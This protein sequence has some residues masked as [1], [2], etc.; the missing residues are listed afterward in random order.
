MPSP[1]PPHAIA[2]TVIGRLIHERPDR[3]S[4]EPGGSMLHHST[5]SPTP[6]LR[7]TMSPTRMPGGAAFLDDGPGPRHGGQGAASG[8]GNLDMS[9]NQTATFSAGIWQ[10]GWLWKRF[11]HG[12]KTTWKRLWVRDGSNTSAACPV[13]I[14]VLCMQITCT[15][16]NFGTA[17]GGRVGRQARLNRNVCAA[18]SGN[19]QCRCHP[20]ASAPPL[21]HLCSSSCPKIACASA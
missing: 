15:R 1:I 20:S 19:A 17:A 14:K 5:D 10:S 9:A 11:G 4:S 7:R 6:A 21:R 12:H 13:R 18:V 16:H 8:G 2:S 3:P